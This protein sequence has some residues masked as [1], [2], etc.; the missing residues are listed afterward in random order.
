MG[1]DGLGWDGM[2]WEYDFLV[3]CHKP[4]FWTNGNFDW[5]NALDENLDSKA[6][7]M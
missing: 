4:K 6:T 5:I 2:G 1:W 7:H 3:F